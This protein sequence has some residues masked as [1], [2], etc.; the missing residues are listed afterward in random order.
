MPKTAITL[1]DDQ[2]RTLVKRMPDILE[3]HPAGA[4][5]LRPFADEFVAAVHEATGRVF[6][7]AIYRRWLPT[8][9]P[10]RMP[11]SDTLAAAALA[12][13]QTNNA[14]RQPCGI[15]PENGAEPSAPIDRSV[16]EQIVSITAHKVVQALDVARRQGDAADRRAQLQIEHLQAQLVANEQRTNEARAGAAR[17]AG[18]LQAARA[19]NEQLQA[20][21]HA[22]RA[23]LEQV[24]KRIDAV[25]REMADLRK[26]TMMAIDGVRGETRAWQDRCKSVEG[27]LQQSRQHLEV[28]RQLA[29]RR[30]ADIPAEILKEAAE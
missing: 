19:V 8:Y 10:G 17:L 21:V 30:G 7:P 13:E 16:I 1:N 3:R 26:M 15:Q 28:F 4:R 18:D 2:A 29:Y 24:S 22:G 23:A 20:E 5:N 12:F 11:A 14:F 27:K 9:A 6:S 25:M